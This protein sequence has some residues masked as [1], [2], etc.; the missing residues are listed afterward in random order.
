MLQGTQVTVATAK[1]KYLFRL[2]REN[3]QGA[4]QA[5]NAGRDR[6]AERQRKP[7]SRGMRPLDDL[8]LWIFLL[9][10]Y[11]S[12]SD[13]L[14]SQNSPLLS[15]MRRKQKMGNTYPGSVIASTSC[16]LC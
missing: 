15:A 3:G 8:L 2:V 7:C 9:P 6:A 4:S 5:E 12:I 11:S 13:F 10:K 14:S 16:R 1:E